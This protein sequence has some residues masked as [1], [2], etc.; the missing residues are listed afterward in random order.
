[1][2]GAPIQHLEGLGA[3]AVL[4]RLLHREQRQAGDDGDH[5]RNSRLPEERAEIHGIAQQHRDAGMPFADADARW[6]ALHHHQAFRGDAGFRIARVTGPVPPPS[7][8]T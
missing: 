7:S 3:D 8:T 5:R 6:A 1:M 4:H 2:K